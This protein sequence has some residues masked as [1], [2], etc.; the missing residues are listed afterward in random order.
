MHVNKGLLHRK[1][2]TILIL[3]TNHI[4]VRDW[5]TEM[6][7]QRVT[8][9]E[10]A[11]IVGIS[12]NSMTTRLKK[13]LDADD[14]IA[15]SR[16]LDISPIH[17]LVEL[18]KLTYKE[19]MDFL[20]GDGTLLASASVEQLIYQLAEDALP[21]SDKISLGAAAKA[22]V[23]NKENHKLS[24]VSD[25]PDIN[26]G[27]VREFDYAP[28]EYAADSSIDETEARLERGEDIID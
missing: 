6:T 22:L 28:E 9:V 16:G 5:F 24:V 7:G 23:D 27:T 21:A 3:M 26:D 18:G 25:A 20:D 2:C 10:M 11:E 19:V 15:I 4:D 12:R 8:A 1:L 14:L 13:G 17:A